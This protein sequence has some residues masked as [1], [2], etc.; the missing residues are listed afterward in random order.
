MS[1]SEQ[2][3]P[4]HPHEP[5]IPP[6]FDDEGRCLVCDL[7]VQ[8]KELRANNA[9]HALEQATA[10]L[11]LADE[12]GAALTDMA[13]AWA[14]VAQACATLELGAQAREVVARLEVAVSYLAVPP[15]PLVSEAFPPEH[16]PGMHGGMEA[17]EPPDRPGSDPS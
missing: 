14:Q 5:A 7:L 16:T 8:I 15:K 2:E 11:E 10:A 17:G 6:A 13:S 1:A 4:R 3:N 9:R 12:R